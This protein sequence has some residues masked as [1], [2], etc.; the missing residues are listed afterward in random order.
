MR[1]TSRKIVVG[2]DGSDLADLALQWAVTTAALRHDP[3]EVLVAA[4][5]PS[6]LAAWT[7]GD[8]SYRDAMRQVADQ[9]E[10]RLADL[11]HSSVPV[12]LVDGDAVPELV[13]AGEDAAMLVV[14]ARGH[15]RLSAVLVGSVSRHLATYA[16]CPVVAVRPQES[17]DSTRIVVGVEPGPSSM[18]ALR[19]ALERADLLGVPLT[20]VHAFDAE[21]PFGGE[22]AL[23]SH[24]KVD[25]GE[26]ERT[27]AEALAGVE[28]DFP[29]VEVTREI[30][31]LRAERV[32]VDAS[33]SAAL[34]VVGARG[35]NPFARLLLGS[36][37]QHVLHHA[38]CPVA[39]VR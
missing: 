19:F 5:L 22:I 13:H 24:L 6:S 7:P 26:A 15:S 31:P 2:F 14:G 9:A 38:H 11:G 10:K 39:V 25:A 37:G 32:L 35:R 16:D 17:P 3:V 34:V 30:V 12:H 1:S 18:P 28:E 4:A 33:Q 23:P 8:N 29:D 36:V 20:V 27:I 21:V